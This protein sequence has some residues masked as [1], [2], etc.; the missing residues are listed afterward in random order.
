MKKL[1]TVLMLSS[2]A[3]MAAAQ[4]N[5]TIYGVVDMGLDRQAGGVAGNVVKMSSGIGSGSRL[6]F[7]GTEDLGGGLSALFVLESGF[8]ADTGALGQGGLLFGRQS[9]V[10][11]KG[12]MG[13]VTLGRQYTPL[14]SSLIEVD[15]F[16][17]GFAPTAANLFSMGSPPAMGVLRMNNAIKYALPA[18]GPISG[19]VTYALGE[20]AGHLGTSAQYGG[21]LAYIDGPVTL[22][23][24]HFSAKNAT[25]AG[26]AKTTML[27]GKYTFG[28]FI[29]H[30][31]VAKNTDTLINT[32]FNKNTVDGLI[33]VTVP[34]GRHTFLGSYIQKFDRDGATS[35][36]AKQFGAGYL[37]ALGKRTDL[38]L[39]YARI[40]NAQPNTAVTA[41]SNNGFYTVGNNIDTGTGDSAFNVGIRHTF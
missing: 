27:S 33:G 26:T 29:L 21:S 38:Y 8:Q 39:A 9:Y 12:D 18:T 37:Y 23:I 7:K 15:P 31:A 24:T 34:Y 35:Y 36:G 4:T 28:A 5:V 17:T 30:G 11:L 1:L 25:A 22:R 14:I 3:E 19:Q 20:V 13:T 6:G 40:K 32:T 10:G 2:V 41:L 16:L